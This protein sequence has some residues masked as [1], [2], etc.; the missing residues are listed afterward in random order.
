MSE[1]VY[2][3]ETRTLAEEHPG[4]WDDVEH[5]GLPSPSPG[6]PRAASAPGTM[7]RSF[8]RNF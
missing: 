5:F 6:T 2:D 4:G 3:I 8:T 7:P 1:I